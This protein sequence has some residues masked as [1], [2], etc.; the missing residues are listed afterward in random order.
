MR[1]PDYFTRPVQSDRL[2]SEYGHNRLDPEPSRGDFLLGLL[3]IGLLVI[4][5]VLFVAVFSTPR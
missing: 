4:A 5:T 3:G 2:H 1:R